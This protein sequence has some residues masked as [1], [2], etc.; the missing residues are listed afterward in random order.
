MLAGN[1]TSSQCGNFDENIKLE[2]SNATYDATNNDALM[3]NK[4][5]ND[6]LFSNKRLHYSPE[7][8]CSALTR[9]HNDTVLRVPI[10]DTKDFHSRAA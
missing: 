1:I 9:K 2:M 4:K 3:R 8:Q 6:I 10:T 7:R 5:K